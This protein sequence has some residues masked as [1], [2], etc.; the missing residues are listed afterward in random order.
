MG[1]EQ[2]LQGRLGNAAHAPLHL[3]AYPSNHACCRALPCAERRPGA[4]GLRLPRHA[5]D[6]VPAAAADAAWG[7]ARAEGLA[8]VPTEERGPAALSIASRPTDLMHLALPASSPHHVCFAV[9]AA[10]PAR[11]C[12]V[13]KAFKDIASTSGDKSQDR[14]KAQIVK[15]LASAKGQEAGYVMRALQVRGRVA[16]CA[17]AG[18]AGRGGRLVGAKRGRACVQP[19]TAQ[20]HALR[21]GARLACC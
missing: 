7:E 17:A 3:P 1:A 16:W 5:E 12:Q 9:S 13:F 20:E 19:C 2:G 15:L 10:C 11:V 6:N 18:E 21:T 4:G 8:A 14:K